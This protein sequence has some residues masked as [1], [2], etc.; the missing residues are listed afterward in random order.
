VVR[1][2]G[3]LADTVVD[4]NAVTRAA[5]TA[6]GFVFTEP[7]PQAL[8]AA[9]G[10]AVGAWRDRAQWRELQCNG[11]LLDFSWR[12]SAERYRDLYRA[13]ITAA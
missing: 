7:A 12:K 13:L 9:L 5:G 4:C 11:M 1:A 2:T 6:N 10:R 3:G 8:L